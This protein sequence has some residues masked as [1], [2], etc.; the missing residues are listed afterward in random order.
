MSQTVGTLGWGYASDVI[1]TS[2]TPTPRDGCG[3]AGGSHRPAVRHMDDQHGACQGALRSVSLEAGAQSVQFVD[4]RLGVLGIERDEPF[5][6]VD[7]NVE[8]R[9]REQTIGQG[10]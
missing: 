9:D 10:V 5:H 6:E 2:H 1:A 3:T 4:C 7:L 8:L